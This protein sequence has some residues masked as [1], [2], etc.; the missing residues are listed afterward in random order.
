MFSKAAV[1]STGGGE[2]RGKGSSFVSFM[3]C[4]SESSSMV[5]LYRRVC[6]SEN[7]LVS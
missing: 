6:V 3:S 4:C 2:P 5:E 7:N 1:E